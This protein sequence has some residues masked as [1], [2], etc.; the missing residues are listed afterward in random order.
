MSKP[1]NTV[2]IGA[3][4]IGALCILVA[5]AFYVS[6]TGFGVKKEKAVLVFDGSVKG[7]KIGAPVAFKGVQIGQVTGIELLMDTDT[8]DVMMPVEIE[9]IVSRI[10]KVGANTEE[11]SL[12]ELIDRGM[13]GQLQSQ[14]LLTGL[15]YIQMDFYPGSELRYA[16][17]D[18]DLLQ[19]PTIRTDMEK[20]SRS[21]DQMDFPALFES[22]QDSLTGL[23]SLIN[24]PETQSLTTNLNKTLTALEQLSYQIQTELDALSPG[25][26]VLLANTDQTV[27]HVNRELPELSSAL[28]ETLTQVDNSLA[29]FRTTLGGVDYTLSDDSAVIYDFRNAATELAKAGRALQSLAETLEEQPESILRGKSALGS[30]P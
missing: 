13:R 15:L 6:G 22:I 26:K 24:N 10:R 9:T 5:T 14:S 3:F 12:E 23:D 7:L 21:L 19:L 8:Y 11:D 25:L 18:S 27:Q 29:A 30:K 28:Q 4:V 17:I 2:A 20:I 16:D 1:V